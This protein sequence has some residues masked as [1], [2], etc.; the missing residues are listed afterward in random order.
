MNCTPRQ[1]Q[2]DMHPL[3]GTIREAPWISEQDPAKAQT[4]QK[5]QLT[6]ARDCIMFLPGRLA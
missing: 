2:R 5:L 1:A 6:A 3:S 4:G